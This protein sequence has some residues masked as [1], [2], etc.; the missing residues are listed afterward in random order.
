MGLIEAL[1]FQQLHDDEGLITAFVQLVD[2]AD[3]GMVERRRSAC[4]TPETL[5]RC[6]VPA[7]GLGEKFNGHR[8][9]QLLVL[10][11]VDNTHSTLAQ[12]TNHPIV[13]K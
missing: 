1:T 3:A 5:Q 2:G 9:A 4:F 7:C 11:L 13:A 6:R 8:T 10:G 12:R